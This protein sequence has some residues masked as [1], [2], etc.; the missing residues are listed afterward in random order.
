M[1]IDIITVII[2]VVA[3]VIIPRPRALSCIVSQYRLSLVCLLLLMRVVEQMVRENT[4]H[5][6]LYDMPHRA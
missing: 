4:K 5:N 6:N 3:V 1:F 2:A